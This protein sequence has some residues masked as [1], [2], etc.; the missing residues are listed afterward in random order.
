MHA[1]GV[2][3]VTA[4]KPIELPAD[5]PA[6]VH[7]LPLKELDPAGANELLSAVAQDG[8]GPYDAEATDRI[9]K[10][11]GGLPLALCIAGSCLGR[12]SPQQLAA[13]L[14]AYGPVEPVERALWLRYTDQPFTKTVREL[15]R[16]VAECA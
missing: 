15:A 3:L 1:S 14:G 10:L 6:W 2:S 11:C 5:L 4:R 7:Q 12:R 13:D 8:S 16:W 9:S